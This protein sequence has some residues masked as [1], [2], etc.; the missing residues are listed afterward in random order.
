MFVRTSYW[1]FKNAVDNFFIN[2]LNEAVKKQETI[3][4]K[5]DGKKVDSK[6]R[7]SDVKFISE[8]WIYD[9]LLPYIRTANQ[10]AKWN[11]D[12]DYCEAAQYTI[13]KKGQHYGWH[14]DMADAPYDTEDISFKGKVRKL[15]CTLLLND[16][17]EYK[18]GSFEFDLRNTRDKENIV[19]VKELENKG[20][21]IVFPSHLWHRVKPV[22]SGKRL[23]LVVWFIGPPFK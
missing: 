19:K 10:S 23:S 8:Q 4:G 17:K 18:G 12:F 16:T 5:I 9:A 6:R 13:Y 3:R 20:D 11:Y 21:L 15:S 14:T 7:E 2:S 1:Y 22:T